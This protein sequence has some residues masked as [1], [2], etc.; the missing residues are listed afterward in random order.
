MAARQLFRWWFWLQPAKQYAATASAVRQA[1]DAGGAA[2]ADRRARE[3]RQEFS[4]SGFQQPVNQ[5]VQAGAPETLRAEVIDD[6][7]NPVTANDG[8]SVQVTFSSGDSGVDLHDA[9]SGIWEATW[10]P[11]N[12]AN[13]V[14][15]QVAASEQGLTLE[16]FPE[17]SQYVDRYGPGSRGR[18]GSAADRN[19]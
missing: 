10:A 3:A 14:K 19:R 1:G 17:R 18:F 12:V 9:G 16:S 4:D 2:G 5:V 7:G 13:Q 6:C 8:G 11:V 15:L